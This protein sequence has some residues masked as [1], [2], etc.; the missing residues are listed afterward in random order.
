MSKTSSEELAGWNAWA[1]RLDTRRLYFRD[2]FQRKASEL[3]E[4]TID[5]LGRFYCDA[6]ASGSLGVLNRW[7]VENR[8]S[9]SFRE[10]ETE[11]RNLVLLFEEL[12]KRG[13]Q[14]FSAQSIRHSALAPSVLNWSKLPQEFRFLGEV[15]EAVEGY[16][17]VSSPEMQERLKELVTDEQRRLL[18]QAAVRVRDLGY[19]RIDSWRKLMGV[20]YHREAALIFDVFGIMDALGLI[21]Y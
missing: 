17:Y 8:R 4:S 18:S 15:A 5:E 19:K 9:D 2:S 20:P 14:P 1:E 21:Y 11:I 7:L 3:S 16:S 12:G 6:L 10:Q 13:W